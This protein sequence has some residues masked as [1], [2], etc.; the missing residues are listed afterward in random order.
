MARQFL[1]VRDLSRI[2]SKDFAPDA[3]A[4]SWGCHSGEMYSAEWKRHFAVPMVGAVGKT[5][6]SHGQLP[7]LSSPDGTW[8]Q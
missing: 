2:D 3:Q 5:D 8:T 7:F 1:H 4:K 6:Y